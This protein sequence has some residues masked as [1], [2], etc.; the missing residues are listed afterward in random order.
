MKNWKKI[1]A[2]CLA[3]VFCAGV[4]LRIW[5]VNL[6]RN[7]GERIIYPMGETAAYEDDFFVNADDI[8]SDY[9]VQIVSAK[10]TPLEEYLKE[11]DTTPEEFWDGEEPL[12]STV[13]EVEAKFRNNCPNEDDSNQHIDLVNTILV[14]GRDWY[15]VQED[16]W[17]LVYPETSPNGFRLAADSEMVVRLPFAVLNHTGASTEY[18]RNKDTYLLISMWP[19][20]KLMQVIPEK[21]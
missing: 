2:V 18:V 5:A 19:T 14:T 11:F 16:L 20:E 10:V 9:E 7:D 8:R 21:S 4:G 17:L 3:V 1:L 15:Q 12:F 13:Y 6:N